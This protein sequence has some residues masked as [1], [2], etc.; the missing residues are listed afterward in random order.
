MHHC[1]LVIAL[2]LQLLLSK[3][4]VISN[5]ILSVVKWFTYVSQQHSEQRELKLDLATRKKQ[6]LKSLIAKNYSE[7][8][9]RKPLWGCTMSLWLMDFSVI[10][11]PFALREKSQFPTG[12]NWECERGQ[13][14][15]FG[16]SFQSWASHPPSSLPVRKPK[17]REIWRDWVPLTLR[18]ILVLVYPYSLTYSLIPEPH[19]KERRR[20]YSFSLPKLSRS[21]RR[22][23][24]EF[25][26]EKKL[27]GGGGG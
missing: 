5:R 25:L 6:L 15:K 7:R 10:L 12:S 13:D 20:K 27:R 1:F 16:Y 18:A 19:Y 22:T 11:S 21:H 8:L 23:A 24:S 4:D 9:P 26:R 17:Q 2:A 3:T 14:V